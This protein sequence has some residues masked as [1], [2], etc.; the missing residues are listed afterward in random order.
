MK[1][2][3]KWCWAV[4]LAGAS[5]L[6]AAAGLK[7]VETADGS[8]SAQTRDL[9]QWT[10][11]RLVF[12][13]PLERVAVG[14]QAT[15]ELEVLGSNEV[16]A[17]AKAVGRTS[18]MVWYTDKTSETFLFSVVQDLT[19]LRRALRDVH[20]GIRLE[21]APDRAA[22]VLRG[23]VPTIKF[24]QAAE[25]VARNYLEVGNRRA[26]DGADILVKAGAA[27]TDADLRVSSS[28]GSAERSTAII[29]LIQV[30]E[31]PRSLE[32]KVRE[33]IVPIGGDNV[34]VGRIQAGDLAD[35][36]ADTLTLSGEVENQVVLTRILN[37]ASRLL[38]GGGDGALAA[39][40]GIEVLA[41]ESGALLGGR[42]GAL[43]DAGSGFS[44]LGGG[45]SLD[46]EI[47]ANIGRSRL[48]AVAGGRIL[49]MIE[50]RDLPQ[51]RVSVQMHEVDR[52]RLKTWRP[53]L[54]LISNGYDTGGRFTID[55]LQEQS[56][57]AS[58]LENALLMVGGALA[59]NL[60]I[61]SG[62]YAFDLLFSLL[63]EEG[64]SR[65]LSRPT[66]T[67]LAGESAVFRA[68]GEVPVPSA[69]APTGIADGDTVGAN[70][71]GVFSGTQFK[72]FG[73]ELRVRAMVDEQDRITLDV[74]PTVSLPDTALTQ[75]IASSTGS[76][77]NTAAF[78][79][80][81]IQTSTRVRDGQP[82]VLG[83]LV[84]R[85][86]TSNDSSTPGISDVPLL[87]RLAESY[88]K[89]DSDTEL[90]IVVTPTIV[91]EPKHETDLWQYPDTRQLLDW[92]VSVAGPQGRTDR[93]LMRPRR[94]P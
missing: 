55:G 45:G 64:I 27:A 2:A 39:V 42:G 79:V 41:D 30:E 52:V 47:R 37:V 33:A 53:D 18:I 56:G 21:L 15:L 90:V 60:Q 76:D 73:V 81:S 44:A 36:R 74:S 87:G 57:T 63:E 20:P 35:D 38:L 85:D 25:S 75:Q 54:S 28:G 92:A 32:Q 12:D 4:L 29:N 82:L 66:L 17:L 19:V 80:R 71:A 3:S 93:S 16:L 6:V 31:L 8:K 14:Q 62:S 86:V 9:I 40:G 58:E 84:T 26:P 83:G 46:N 88:S 24:R 23:T 13:K 61:A 89:G 59:N 43:S 10:H 78:D 70:A 51:V 72:A 48:L 50:V 68:G 11:T 91:R 1:Q 67:V 49:S 77:L 22:L 65:T 94:Q 69:F 34:T 5:Q 7:Y